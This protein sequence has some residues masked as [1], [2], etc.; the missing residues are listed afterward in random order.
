MKVV[1]SITVNG[2]DYKREIREVFALN[3]PQYQL[4]ITLNRG[5]FKNDML[6]ERQATCAIYV[7]FLATRN[8]NKAPAMRVSHWWC[9]DDNETDV[10]LVMTHTGCRFTVEHLEVDNL[11]C[12]ERDRLHAL[13]SELRGVRYSYVQNMFGFLEKDGTDKK[14][15][16][17]LP[18]PL[19]AA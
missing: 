12:S 13:F 14:Q 19:I 18:F 15:V 3:D 17:E 2:D 16:F 10:H 8:D 4:E 7:R 5:V 1:K 11:A 9:A 6:K